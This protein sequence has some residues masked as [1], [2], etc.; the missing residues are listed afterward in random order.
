[1][2]VIQNSSNNNRF[3]TGNTFCG[4]SSGKTTVSGTNN[5]GCGNS[6]MSGITSGSS[7]CCIG[8]SAGSSYTTESSNIA[9]M[10]TGT[11]A[12]ANQIR[13]GT[14]GTGT[15]QQSACSIAGT[16]TP[17][18]NLNLLATTSTVGNI[19]Q[20]STRILHTFGSNNIFV[21]NSAGNYT[22]SGTGYNTCLGQSAGTVLSTG[23]LNTFIGGNSGLAA[24]T[25]I[26]NVGIG[27]ASLAK[28]TSPTGNVGAG[29][30][31]LNNLITGTFNIA[32]GYASG[33]SYTGA[34][35]SNILIQNAGTVGESN[36][37]RIGVDGTG[38]G[39]QNV[40][41]IAGISGVTTGALGTPVLVDTNGNLGTISS[42]EKTKEDIANMDSSSER[43]Y[44]LRP[45]TF[46]YKDR[47]AWGT[48]FGLIA[49]EVLDVL[50]ELVHFNKDNEPETVHY[51]MLPALLLNE[52][53]KQ[54]KVIADLLNRVKILER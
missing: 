8:N 9:I 50:P 37:I 11:G 16:V 6:S 49:E 15:G 53:Q 32:I 52:L 23:N 27:S 35:S 28:I 36:V 30:S 20:A 38:A 54:N 44:S 34:E 48:Q 24:T 1:M 21:G 22:T 18:R 3:G 17:A 5:T 12:D 4:P 47:R 43:I 10:H 31:T 41:Y 33:T 40:C 39:Q 29:P 42:S 26:E 46:R 45:V 7:N 25:A 51:H 13:I 2:A 19:T 14:D